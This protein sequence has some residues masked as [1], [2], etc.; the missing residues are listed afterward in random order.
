M[1]SA[2]RPNTTIPPGLQSCGGIPG[3]SS[4][5]NVP[6]AFTDDINSALLALQNFRSPRRPAPGSA[7]AAFDAFRLSLIA[8]AMPAATGRCSSPDFED[9]ALRL[10]AAPCETALDLAMKALAFKVF[11]GTIVVHAARQH[12]PRCMIIEAATLA[13][14]AMFLA[15]DALALSGRAV[16]Q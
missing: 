13:E 12:D 14:L 16:L 8:S 4:N 11:T 15:A 10:A 9:A 6:A 5:D 1:L 2:D 7:G 3:A